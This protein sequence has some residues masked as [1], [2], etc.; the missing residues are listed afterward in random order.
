MNE[1]D[2]RALENR[3]LEEEGIE[4]LHIM[5]ETGCVVSMNGQGHF[6]CSFHKEESDV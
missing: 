5:T 2:L 1:D 6:P 3:L 4:V